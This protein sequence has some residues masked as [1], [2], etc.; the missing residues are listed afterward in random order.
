MPAVSTRAAAGAVAAVAVL[1]VFFAMRGG[2]CN[3]KKSGATDG[4]ADDDAA[5]DAAAHVVHGRPGCHPTLEG[6]TLAKVAPGTLSLAVVKDRAL[7]VSTNGARAERIALD[8]MGAATGA[9]ESDTDALAPATGV[10]IFAAATA[11]DGYLGTLT[12]AARRPTPADCADGLLVTKLFEA[13][14]P[15]REILAHS[16]RAASLLA[17]ATRGSLGIA[18]LDGATKADGDPKTAPAV[19]DVVVIA[20]L[21]SAQARVETTGEGATIAQAAAAAGATS[22][23]AAWVVAHGG[24]R[25]LHVVQL[26]ANGKTTTKV[27]V[28]DK[29][30]VGT[31]TLAYEGDVLHVVW[32][33]FVPQRN[34]SVLRWSKWLAGAEPSAAQ[35]IG[36]GVLSA[37]TPSLAIDRGRF[38]LAWANGDEKETTVKV[39]ASTS[40]IAAIAGLANVVSTPT[41]HAREPVVALDGDAMF[42]AWKEL[43]SGGGE[44]GRDAGEAAARVHAASISCR[45]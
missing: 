6:G 44:R 45:E 17:A 42:V 5:A 20:G 41:V 24:T 36:T 16:C 26:G 8:R 9:V 1:A 21:T 7:L 38:M 11:L 25:E 18:V 3:D 28:L 43:G 35:T 37:V 29:E 33:S 22:V 13:G 4:G 34:R 19:A 32:S 10:T 27:E 30:N 15:R 23:A 40:G 39:G 2:A 31:V 14:A 12:Y